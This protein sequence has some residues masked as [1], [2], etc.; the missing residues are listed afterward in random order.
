MHMR[1]NRSEERGTGA[2]GVLKYLLVLDESGLQGLFKSEDQKQM[3]GLGAGL[4]V[5]G[6]VIELFGPSLLSRVTMSS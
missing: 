3:M 4:Y 5:H 2:R 1:S 6:P